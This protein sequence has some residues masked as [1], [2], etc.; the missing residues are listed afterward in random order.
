MTSRMEN[1]DFKDYLASPEVSCSG[2]KNL[3]EKDGCP[4]KYKYFVIDKNVKETEPMRIGSAFHTLVLQPELFDEEYLVVPNIK[5]GSAAWGKAQLDAGSR[6]ILKEKDYTPLKAMRDAISNHPGASDLLTD[7]RNETSIFWETNG[8]GCRGQIDAFKSNSAGV[9]LID[10]KSTQN[11]SKSFFSREIFTRQYHMQAAFYMDGYRA[12][13]G[14][15]PTVFF[16]I[17][18]EKTAPYLINIFHFCYDDD[19]I[20]QGRLEYENTLEL[21]RK[22]NN[23]DDWSR[24][25][26]G[27]GESNRVIMPGYYT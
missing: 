2:M 21:Y 10:L 17:A 8:I 19:A 25:Y 1:I 26:V 4:Q 13:T 22:C 12:V 7:T 11:A 5:K 15:E 9:A 3:N 23:E 27:K 14:V 20:H 16:F 24:G 6:R 18:A